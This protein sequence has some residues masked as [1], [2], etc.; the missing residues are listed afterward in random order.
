MKNIS[1]HAPLGGGYSWFGVFFFVCNVLQ[2]TPPWGGATPPDSWPF[3]STL[4]SIH[5]PLA[6]GDPPMPAR[7]WERLI[8]IHAPLAGGDP[9]ATLSENQ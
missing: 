1:I 5:A 8:S 4:I 6:G 7:A 9:W 3:F 2:P